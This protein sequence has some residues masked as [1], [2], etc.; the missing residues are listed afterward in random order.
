MSLNAI[1]V[2]LIHYYEAVLAEQM[3]IIT[4]VQSQHQYNKAL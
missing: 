3:T 1:P 4:Q 2:F